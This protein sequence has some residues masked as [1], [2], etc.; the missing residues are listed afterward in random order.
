MATVTI[1]P[2]ALAPG[3]DF[4][5]WT[6]AITQD[7][8]IVAHDD[9]LQVG[10]IPLTGIVGV[11]TEVELPISRD[12]GVY[13]LTLSAEG[14]TWS[15]PFL[16]L[17]GIQRSVGYWIKNYSPPAQPPTEG[18]PGP[19]G[20][21]YFFA[22]LPF[23]FPA[24]TAPTAKAASWT[25]PL[26]S[27]L[28]ED[29]ILA[30]TPFLSSYSGFLYF[31]ADTNGQYDFALRIH[32]QIGDVG[33]LIERRVN[34]RVVKAE[35][36]TLL[37]SAFES[38]SEVV[39]GPF[40]DANG[41]VVD[42]TPDLLA[43]P[44]TCSF[45]LRVT[46]STGKNFGVESASISQAKAWFSQQALGIGGVE[47][48]PGV[49]GV[50]ISGIT[51]DA[52][53]R[54]TITLTDGTRTGPFTLP[55]G[56]QGA[57]VYD[58][59]RVVAANAVPTDAPAGGS[60]T[61]TTQVLVPPDGWSLS[62]ADPGAGQVLVASR[63]EI[64]PVGQGTTIVP[65]WSVP[66]V[67]GGTGAAGKPGTD[68][69]QGLSSLRVYRKSSTGTTPAKPAAT[70]WTLSANGDITF[71][72]PS[73]WSA[74]APDPPGLLEPDA[75][76]F[77]SEAAINPADGVG[78]HTAAWGEPIPYTGRR[79][80]AGSDGAD[81]EPGAPGNR[82]YWGTGDP[83]TTRPAGVRSGDW[84]FNTANYDVW[85]YDNESTWNKRGNL[86]GAKGDK[87][88]PGEGTE[89]QFDA[90]LVLDTSSGTDTVSLQDGGITNR[91]VG[92]SAV[93]TGN[94]AD[95]A[96]TGGKIAD[97]V[98]EGNPATQSADPVL[99][100]ITVKGQ[101]YRNPAN[102]TPTGGAGERT[103][104]S[105]LSKSD[106]SANADLFQKTATIENLHH[107]ELVTF[108][109]SMVQVST[110]EAWAVFGSR[111]TEGDVPSTDPTGSL[112]GTDWRRVGGQTF[113]G[114]DTPAL[115]V[116]GNNSGVMSVEAI[117]NGA[118]GASFD[119]RT[120]CVLRSL[121]GTTAVSVTLAVI[122]AAAAVAEVVTKSPVGGTGTADDPLTII[123]GTIHD[124][125]LANQSVGPG[126][127]KPKATYLD[128]KTVLRAGANV[129]VTPNDTAQ[130]IVVAAQ[131]SGRPIA[132]EAEGSFWGRAM[133][134]TDAIAHALKLRA[135]DSHDQ[136]QIQ[137]A[138]GY[139]PGGGTIAD[140][141]FQAQSGTNFTRWNCSNFDDNPGSYES[142][143]PGLLIDRGH[144]QLNPNGVDFS[145]A[146]AGT[147]TRVMRIRV[148]FEPD[149]QR[150]Y[151]ADEE[152]ELWVRANNGSRIRTPEPNTV[153]RHTWHFA[154]GDQ[155]PF[156]FTFDLEFTGAPRRGTADGISLNL[157]Y[158][159]PS[160]QVVALTGGIQVEISLPAL[161]AIPA[162]PLTA[163]AESTFQVPGDRSR[164]IIGWHVPDTNDH[165]GKNEPGE[166]D[167]AD[168]HLVRPTGWPSQADSPFLQ[169]AQDLQQVR[170]SMS[171]NFA[172]D[173][174]GGQVLLLY[175][176]PAAGIGPT[177]L[178]TVDHPASGALT[179][180]YTQDAVLGGDEFWI[181]VLGTGL[182]Q[183]TQ[184][185]TW[186]AN[187]AGGK[188]VLSTVIEGV[189]HTVEDDLASGNANGVRLRT[190]VW[191][192][193]TYP[194]LIEA[195]KAG[196]LHELRIYSNG[197][198]S[199]ISLAGRIPPEGTDPVNVASRTQPVVFGLA[200]RGTETG[201]SYEGR[202]GA[203][204]W[205]D[206]DGLNV[207]FQSV[208]TPQPQVW[209]ENI[210]IDYLT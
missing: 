28:F 184:T 116:S 114:R 20:G 133:G 130:E 145:N 193:A 153:V 127:L 66:F 147:T 33:F 180:D 84:W 55:Q 68:G 39:V 115:E 204:F 156:D 34:R 110:S 15:R 177:V 25:V 60:F 23:D 58:I 161:G 85:R 120:G 195:A 86:K 155:R 47:P 52:T 143:R 122:R 53:G 126:K 160:N 205:L 191:P 13:V 95:G 37:L 61:T 41:D 181:A 207:R 159:P 134:Q 16:V 125:Q 11:D 50:G 7:P 190:Y 174:R 46:E 137:D 8:P 198:D 150:D 173:G 154:G 109:L 64:N 5:G 35:Q 196:R 163:A 166:S 36:F 91:Y 208:G 132:P 21:Y 209:I 96:V 65:D 194:D 3:A 82:W 62:P 81:G 24:V 51:E 138:Y 199:A 72:A 80:R 94:L 32:H 200:P 192:A 197:F 98:I 167:R 131:Q 93:G 49:P 79:G 108:V 30:G 172:S 27:Q 158:R 118:E 89:I 22:S 124:V 19:P 63:A 171:G 75:R 135:I 57:S 186:D 42:I 2:R 141:T 183:G 29:R 210:Q 164:G 59:Y 107:G 73:N 76:V 87:G 189:I 140:Q 175:R 201:S 14:R 1:N 40:T 44:V 102:A 69:A 165:T 176:S 128:S 121:G 168:I 149:N 90:P 187:V 188:P 88:D 10:T 67:A 162:Q 56:P 206:N 77:A 74:E 182:G 99:T 45:E 18:P 151:G 179:L 83:V 113:R 97:G 92:A 100:G 12:D 203:N 146:T 169:A 202:L 101:R 9:G 26:G 142:N 148:I 111:L 70:T 104:L 119:I 178:A 157:Q 112:S 106:A 129:T 4:T 136:R 105:T 170:I 48:L 17:D 43:S 78:S 31:D 144:N 152:L 38:E 123:P 54:L 117:W 103:V 71:A 139:I 185:L 6:W